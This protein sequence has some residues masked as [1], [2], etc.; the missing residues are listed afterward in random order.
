MYFSVIVMFDVYHNPET[1]G[2]G[3]IIAILWMRK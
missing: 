3:N 1:V 2:I